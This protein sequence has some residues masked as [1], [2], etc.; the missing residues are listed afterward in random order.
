MGHVGCSRGARSPAAVTLSKDD[1][2][3]HDLETLT[4]VLDNHDRLNRRARRALEKVT[5]KRSKQR[6]AA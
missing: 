4:Q 3:R 2:P 6:G 1:G 5:T